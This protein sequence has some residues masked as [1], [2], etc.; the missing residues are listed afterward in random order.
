[1]PLLRFPLRMSHGVRPHQNSERASFFLA[2]NN[3]FDWLCLPLRSWAVPTQMLPPKMARPCSAQSWPLS[4]PIDASEPKPSSAP[5]ALSQTGWL[6]SWLKR[7]PG[8][9]CP[10]Q[11]EQVLCPPGLPSLSDK[12]HKHLVSSTWMLCSHTSCMLPFQVARLHSLNENTLHLFCCCWL[13]F[14]YC[15]MMILRVAVPFSELMN[16][17]CSV[18]WPLGQEESCTRNTFSI[19]HWCPG[20]GSMELLMSLSRVSG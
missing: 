1:M 9:C 7:W 2:P 3:S 20:L 16:S 13:L 5:R 19:I 18:R 6:S 8:S 15:F 17:F 4:G 11:R 12:F 10:H 14:F